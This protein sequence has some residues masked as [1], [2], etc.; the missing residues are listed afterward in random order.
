MYS[1]Y[2]TRLPHSMDAIT[3]SESIIPSTEIQ[4]KYSFHSLGVPK[5]WPFLCIWFYNVVYIVNKDIFHSSFVQ[6]LVFLRPKMSRS[7]TNSAVV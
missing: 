2:V 6:C 1:I 7:E 5:E 4:F 3:I